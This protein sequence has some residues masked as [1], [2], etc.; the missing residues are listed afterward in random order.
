MTRSM[1]YIPAVQVKVVMQKIVCIIMPAIKDVLE[2]A[3]V[4]GNTRNQDEQKHAR[5]PEGAPASPAVPRQCRGPPSRAFLPAGQC[6][7]PRSSGT[8]MCRPGQCR[9]A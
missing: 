8:Q 2:H 7:P 5:S 3:L 6:P 9:C 1:E 4:Y